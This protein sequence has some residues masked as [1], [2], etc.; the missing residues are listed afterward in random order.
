MSIL[1]RRLRVNL[2]N[3]RKII[4]I[5]GRIAFTGG[6]NVGDEYLGKGPLGHWRDTMLEIEGPAVASLQ[7]TFAEDWNFASG[8]TL[9][10]DAYKPPKLPP[11]DVQI[12]VIQSGPD[13][14]L[15][16][17]REIYF[18]AALK[19]RKKLWI[20][21]PYYVPDAG[22]RDALCL[23]GRSGID[24]K[25]LIPKAADHFHVHYASQYYLSELLDA[26]VEVFHYTN[27]FLHSKVWIA[28]G[29]WASVGTANLDN[30]SLLLNFEVNCMLYT[31]TAI[32][33][34]ER[35]FEADLKNSVRLDP[36]AFAKRPWTEKL[37][38]N[39]CRLFSPTL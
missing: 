6:M 1:R 14:D 32:A 33:Q 22:L 8:E 17:I 29:H 37:A 15:K 7:A 4:V 9:S 21:T 18:A 3:H 13:Y 27:G 12:Q 34:L 2:R 24:V 10:A 31:R 28:D 30:R 16:S 25:L 36:K 39:F 38:E 23:A 35:A 11:G 26:G 20:S 5:D 19:A